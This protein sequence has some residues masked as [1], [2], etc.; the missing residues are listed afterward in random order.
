MGTSRVLFA[1][2]AEADRAAEVAMV[3]AADAVS[4]ALRAGTPV[5]GFELQDTRGNAVSLDRLLA[6]G[7][8]VLNFFRGAWCTFGEESLAQ[9]ATTYSSIVAAGAAAFAIAP[10]TPRSAADRLLPIPELVDLDMKVARSFGLAFELPRELRQRY[11]DLGY[12]P[13]RI[14]RSNSFLV[15]IPA[16]YLIDQEGMIVLAHID[17][18]YRHQPGNEALVSALQALRARW[19]S[20]GKAARRLAGKR[21]SGREV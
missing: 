15:P 3:A 12:V 17:P 6:T 2:D 8:V 14:R 4:R 13:P 19:L 9:L 21:R 1:P 7:P 16:T 5:P 10:P 11:L 18:D 20:R